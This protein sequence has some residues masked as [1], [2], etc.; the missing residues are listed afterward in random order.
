MMKQYHF[1]IAFKVPSFNVTKCDNLFSDWHISG[2]E[3]PDWQEK[4][5]RSRGP[6]IW[7]GPSPMSKWVHSHGG[8]P[9]WMVFVRENLIDMI[10]NGWFGGTPTTSETPH[11]RDVS[12]LSRNCLMGS[13]L[14]LGVD[15][16]NP[17]WHMLP[18][19]VVTSSLD[20]KRPR[21]RREEVDGS[22]KETGH[23]GHTSTCLWMSLVAFG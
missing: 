22:A 1:A 6:E 15:S 13:A 19:R 16:T 4:K 8:Y 18:P 12:I 3:R 14:L 21:P 11:G 2:A 5:R 23:Q 7:L 20:R 10:K 9:K 17:W